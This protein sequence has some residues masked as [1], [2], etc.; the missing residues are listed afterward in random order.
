M[1]GPGQF[2]I[3]ADGELVVG[4]DENAGLWEH[5]F[6]NQGFPTPERVVEL[7]EERLKEDREA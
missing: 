3:F 1:G 6:G 5:L 4:K 7:I 2:D